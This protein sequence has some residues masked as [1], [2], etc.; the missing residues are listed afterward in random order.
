M[1]NKL[2]FLTKDKGFRWEQFEAK[3]LLHTKWNVF[4]TKI[5]PTWYWDKFNIDTK[6]TYFWNKYQIKEDTQYVWDK[7]QKIDELVRTDYYWDKHN[8]KKTPKYPS[9]TKDTL[10]SDPTYFWKRYN[11]VETELPVDEQRALAYTNSSPLKSGQTFFPAYEMKNYEDVWAVPAFHNAKTD[12]GYEEMPQKYSKPET[13]EQPSFTSTRTNYVVNNNYAR[14]LKGPVV[15]GFAPTS[16]GSNAGG[17][18]EGSQGYIPAGDST[19]GYKSIG[20]VKLEICEYD[21]NIIK[22]KT[23]WFNTDRNVLKSYTISDVVTKKGDVDA[24]SNYLRT[25]INMAI[26][27][28][29]KVILIGYADNGS[30]KNN[31]TRSDLS[32]PFAINE[33]FAGM[34]VSEPAIGA[35]SGYSNYHVR[36]GKNFSFNKSIELTFCRP[37]YS[38]TQYFHFYYA[39]T[40]AQNAKSSYYTK[41]LKYTGCFS[42]NLLGFFPYTEVT[43]TPVITDSPTGKSFSNYLLDRYN[44]ITISTLVPRV[45]G[46]Y[47][48]IRK[49]E[50]PTGVTTLYNKNG[51]TISIQTSS[52]SSTIYITPWNIG[53]KDY[54]KGDTYLG[55]V[56]SKQEHQYPAD[57]YSDGFWYTYDRAQTTH[58]YAKFSQYTDLS[59]LDLRDWRSVESTPQLDRDTGQWT[60]T[61]GGDGTYLVPAADPV[62]TWVQKLSDTNALYWTSKFNDGSMLYDYGEYVGA[63]FLDSQYY[64]DTSVVLEYLH[65]AGSFIETLTTNTPTSFPLDGEDGDFWYIYK[66]EVPIINTYKGEFIEQVSYLNQFLYPIDGAD[67]DYWYVYSHKT[68][69]Y[70]QGVYEG[71]VSDTS[72]S[73]YPAN[74]IQNG[75][76]YKYDRSEF[77]NSKG[78]YIESVTA[79]SKLYPSDGIS[80]FYYYVLTDFKNI[81]SKD[82][83][84]GAEDSTDPEAFPEDGA[85]GQFWYEKASTYTQVDPTI[86]I[87]DVWSE[88]SSTYPFDGVDGNYWYKYVGER[89]IPQYIIGDS[90]L[91]KGIK[92]KQDINSNEDYMP[93]DVGCAE[94][95]FTIFTEPKEAQKYLDLECEYFYRMND[96]DGWTRVGHFTVTSASDKTSTTTNLKAYDNVIKTE[97]I[98][99]S[100]LAGLSYP[101]KLK[102]MYLSLCEFCGLEGVWGDEA[103]NADF[104]VKNN[105]TT[106]QITARQ[107]FNLIA[108][109]AC[110]F[111]KATEDG[112]LILNGYTAKHNLFGDSKYKE[113]TQAI[114][115]VQKINK[116]NIAKSTEDLGYSVGSGDVVYRIIDNPLFYFERESEISSAAAA[117]FNKVKDITYVPTEMTIYDPSALDVGDIISVNDEVVYVMSRE[118]DGSRVKISCKGQRERTVENNPIDGSI[119]AL[120]GKS[121]ELTRTIDETNSRITDVESGLK[122]EISQTSSSINS[123]I[124]DEVNKVNS[125][126]TQ[127]SNSLTTKINNEI[128]GV[129]SKIEQ[130]ESSLNTS[131][132]DT[133]QELESSISQTADSI[134]SRITSQGDTITEIQQNLDG[135]KL[136]YNSEQG[137]AS[138]TIGNVTVT[139][140][141][142]GQYVNKVVAGI[143]L[144]GYVTFHSLET[145]GA[146]TING[147]NITT[148]T[149]D[150]DRI[151][152]TGAISW[153][154]LS[155][156]CKTTIRD[157]ASGASVSIPDYIHSTYIDSVK[158]ISPTIQ[159]G[160]ISAG[161]NADGYM[162][163]SSTGMNFN[164]A[165]GSSLA[166][167]GYAT[168]KYLYPYLVLGG[169]VDS[170]GTDRGLVKKYS[171]GIWI[172]DSDSIDEGANRPSSGTGLFVDFANNRLYKV[173]NGKYTQL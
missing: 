139:N 12:S 93:G 107:I 116:V 148:G 17:L 69:L 68:P 30:S 57:G 11:A 112:Q 56:H 101:I 41:T 105:F 110:G 29:G 52:D 141:V 133:K 115:E 73:A 156:S 55:E 34:V 70:S 26:S 140:L 109:A 33:G 161:T 89:Y 25:E 111:I 97:K 50:I 98:A 88:D 54:S 6:Q 5:I 81:V 19:K 64:Q 123:R 102:D 23:S 138:I 126:I 168:G 65:S 39:P 63:Q 44:A 78:E 118:W 72:S 158:I 47:N 172:G 75:Q 14:P 15:R 104:R 151:N 83:Y 13:I 62:T 84:V 79:Q 71:W 4:K 16:L 2:E 120:R 170:V 106:N 49:S 66:K 131:I 127:T 146:T 128:S 145:A 28:Y 45:S 144:T 157:I 22:S 136:T 165:G 27:Q 150:A 167:L 85:S 166:G 42:T 48:L 122:S 74:G 143:D 134:N 163:L 46:S 43:T 53:L 7:Y 125:S 154:D 114:Y 3:E 95:Q 164:R 60:Y 38:D 117:I 9:W 59:S 108:E 8:I 121:N 119:D 155:S 37:N 169:G 159:G 10:D 99:D 76:W 18:I 61:L 142:D 173:I 35:Y 124:T 130:T 20:T 80:G 21:E 51:V 171:G 1:K 129:N 36:V 132:S 160:I 137:T 31:F 100:W 135:I 24:A 92:Y 103:V 94:I 86:Y 152:L 96:T 153:G 147:S 113:T 58:L 32:Y 67:G 149:I 87:Q 82:E 77:I 91:K 90:L 162:V 40:S